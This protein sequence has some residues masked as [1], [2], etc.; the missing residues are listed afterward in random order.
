MMTKLKK[1]VDQLVQSELDLASEQHGERFH[2]AHEAYAVIREEQDEAECDMYSARESFIEFWK[3]VKKDT[4]G[5]LELKETEN[6][7]ID[8]ACE[9]IQM[10]AMTRKAQR[11]YE[12]DT[13]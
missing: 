9:F 8:A 10:A 3:S 4:D 12:E 7:A 2:S 1:T 11:G 5:S 6:F 13:K